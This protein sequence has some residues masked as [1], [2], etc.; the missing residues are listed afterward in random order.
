MV[1]QCEISTSH[2]QGTVHVLN[3]HHIVIFLPFIF[4]S[5]IHILDFFKFFFKISLPTLYH[6]ILFQSFNPLFNLTIQV[7][8]L[9]IQYFIY[10]T[11]SFN[12]NVLH[13][14]FQSHQLTS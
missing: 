12:T 1:N 13:P 7:F 5:N 14:L 9:N 11:H 4:Y 3:H 2:V 6:T 8:N 10:T